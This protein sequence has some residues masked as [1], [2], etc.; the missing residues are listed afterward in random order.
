M[1]DGDYLHNMASRPDTTGAEN[2]VFSTQSSEFHVFT[3]GA[4]KSFEFRNETFRPFSLY[5]FGGYSFDR[6]GDEAPQTG[7]GLR[8]GWWDGPDFSL[9]AGRTFSTVLGTSDAQTRILA[10]INWSM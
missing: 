7:A 5:A 1:L 3:L 2:E 4:S 6:L 8:G 10:T 9:E